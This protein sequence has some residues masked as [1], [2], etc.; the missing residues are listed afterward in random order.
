M[1]PISITSIAAPSRRLL[2]AALFAAAVALAASAFGHPAVARAD[3][4]QNFYDWCMHN[5][6]EGNQYCCEHAGGVIRSAVCVDPAT[7][8]AQGAPAQ[9]T[10][11]H[12]LPVVAG[13]PVTAANS[14]S[15]G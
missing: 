6:G 9:R 5:L 14:G 12:P 2:S 11:G 3:F 8:K 7:P 13:I 1:S 4:D 15:S 10:T